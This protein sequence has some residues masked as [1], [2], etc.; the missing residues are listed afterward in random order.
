MQQP[1][2]LKTG[3]QSAITQIINEAISFVESRGHKAQV[4]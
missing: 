4:Y 3:H 2:Q 1:I